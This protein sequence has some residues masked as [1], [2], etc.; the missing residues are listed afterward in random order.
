MYFYY[1][2][3][4]ATSDRCK[5]IDAEQASGTAEQMSDQRT[6]GQYISYPM[7]LHHIPQNNNVDIVLKN[8]ELVNRFDL[9][10]L[11]KTTPY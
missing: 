5:F 11:G 7:S 6:E 1:R 10:H 9:L 2:A 8:L 3:Y 4:L